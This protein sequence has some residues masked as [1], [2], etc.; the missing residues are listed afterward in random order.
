MLRGIVGP[1]RR[2]GRS[3]LPSTELFFGIRHGQIPWPSI[4]LIPPLTSIS[5]QLTRLAARWRYQSLLPL[6]C[7]GINQAVHLTPAS[8]THKWGPNLQPKEQRRVIHSI[9]SRTPL[10]PALSLSHRYVSRRQRFA[11]KCILGSSVRDSY[12]SIR[13]HYHCIVSQEWRPWIHSY[14]SVLY[15]LYLTIA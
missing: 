14:P 12:S 8:S 2:E 11:I 10:D 5:R 4:P 6:R 7:C 1:F 9:P 15:V 3:L 13:T